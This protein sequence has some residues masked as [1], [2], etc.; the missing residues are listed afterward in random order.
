MLLL[1][2]S[3]SVTVKIGP[4]VDEDD[5]KTAE[6]GLTISQAD[7]RLSMNGGNMAQKN[8]SSACT[9]DELGV[10]GCPIDTTDTGTLG[11]L[12]L[13]VH[14]SGALPVW[15]EFMVIP[16]N[17][18]DS[19]VSG[20]D[21]L[22]VDAV[23]LD[24]TAQRATDL[25]EIA[26]YLIANAPTL[27]DVVADDSILAKLMATDGDIS[28]FAE[29][30]DSLQSIRDAITDA[31]PQNHTATSSN[32]TTGTIVS[33]T[34]A[35][36]ATDN[37]TYWQIAPV[38][39]AVGGFGLNVDLVFGI[40]TGRV[41]SSVF[42]NG[43]WNADPPVGSR[44]V[45]VW[46]Y[47][48]LSSTWEQIS[49][50]GTNL[51]DAAADADYQYALSVDHVQTSD[52]EVKIR[53]TATSTDT[54]DD[55]Y[56]DQVLVS[57]VAQEA[58]GLT[59]QAIAT[60][61]W[62]FPIAGHD[63][64]TVGYAVGHINILQGDVSSAT[65]ASQFIIDA[66]VAVNDAYNGMLIMLEDKTD[67]HYEVRRIIDYIGATNEI[68]VDRAFGFTPVANDDYYIM[69]AGYADVNVT[70]IE[71]S[72]ATD[73]INAAVDAA[74][75]TSI[76]GSPTAN[77]INQRIV[78]I[79]DLTQ[80]SGGGDLAAIIADTNE[81]QGDWTNGGR[82]DLILDAIKAITDLLTLAAIADGVWDEATSG[83][84][85]AGSTGKALTDC[86]AVGAGAITFTYTLTSSV[87][88]APIGSATVWVTSDEAGLY[89]VASGTTDANGEVVFY[90]DA[91]TYYVWRYKVGWNFTN[92]D[93]EAVA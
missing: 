78:A 63:D 80:A 15:H 88:S 1:K 45:E 16:A 44:T 17:E 77:S 53:F 27:T 7:V 8:E 82:L 66:G 92:P 41:P 20:S 67:D 2:Q 18:Y 13:F 35:D 86:A 61:V 75:N 47:N 31:N 52:G 46:A 74:L 9:H 14:E 49:D 56:L 24:G 11:R 22:Q 85:A 48:Y 91:G 32:D 26:Q 68:F 3:T 36:T 62:D 21:A 83:H 6:T 33:G 87:D 73:Q 4:F 71:A 19:L 89:V 28:G 10:Y 43:Y 12:Q 38:S 76:P 81:L 25:A 57:S 42:V 34:Y 79:D 54:D 70:D 90:L 39:P 55:L 37:G 65:S 30:T 29:A 59:A 60:T 93:T 64:A 69:S 51:D 23:E 84:Q 72:D 40:G 5:G 58:A 50:S